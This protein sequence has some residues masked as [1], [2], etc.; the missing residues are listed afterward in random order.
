MNLEPN[1]PTIGTVLRSRDELIE[2]LRA[3]KADLGL[4]NAFIEEQMQ[5]AAG[6]ADKVLGPS[7]TKG[8]SVHVVFD[9]VDLMGGRLVF[10]VDADTEA[11]MRDRWERRAESQVRAPVRISKAIMERAKPLLFA[12]LGKAGGINRAKCLT[13]KQRREIARTAALSRW[14]LHRAAAKASAI[15]EVSA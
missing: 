15:A 10:Q 7:G 8:M 11:R 1:A 9:L 3:R 12:A 5:M 14:R 2:L 13:A 4:S 6:G